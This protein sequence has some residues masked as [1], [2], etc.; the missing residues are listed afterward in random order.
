M[1][2]LSTELSIYGSMLLLAI[3]QGLSEFLP[4]SS[5]GH[6]AL[7]QMILGVGKESLTAVVVLHAGTLVAVLVYYRKVIAELAGGVFQG[8][9]DVD[10][11]SARSYVG[12]LV[13]GNVPAAI[14][15]L[16]FRD[17]IEGLFANPW[18]VFAAM[19]ATAAV[20]WST[21]SCVPGV[22]APDARRALLIGC[23]QA[24]AIL[25]GASRSGWTIAVALWLGLRPEAAARF[26][27]LLSIPAIFG[28]L[29][30]E[31]LD[32]DGLDMPVGALLAGF[33]VA[34]LTG[35]F[36]LRWLV[37]LVRRMELFRFAIYLCILTTVGVG[38]LLLR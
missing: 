30:L 24:L 11:L 26:S 5:S 21:R 34:A 33:V 37:A 32:H 8:G 6:L 29:L 14:L 3:I 16:G 10:G 31:V 20:L 18:A 12:M 13:L 22:Q 19:L 35:L 27:F 9:G 4:V 28:A 1:E 2:S 7:G 15:G 36:A 17:Q 25:P 38:V 23:A